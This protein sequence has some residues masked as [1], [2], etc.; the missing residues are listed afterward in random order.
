MSRIYTA[1]ASRWRARLPFLL[2]GLFVLLVVAIVASRLLGLWGAETAA[3]GSNDITVTYATEGDAPGSGVVNSPLKV[4]VTVPWSTGSQDTVLA[5]VALQLLDDAGNPAVFGNGPENEAFAMKPTFDIAVW[6]WRGSVPSKPGKYH[7]RINIDALYNKARNGVV[8]LS[9]PTV[10]AKPVAGAPLT[11]GFVFSQD[12]NLW[13]LSSDAT[14]QRKITFFPE[15]YEY[16]DKPVWSP[17]GSKIAFTYSPRTDPSALPATDIWQVGA[18]G[19][20]AKP[21]VEHGDGESLLD[22]AWSADGKYVYYTVDTSASATYT[23]TLGMPGGGLM[24]TSVRIDRT[25]IATGIREQWMPASQMP[26]SGEANGDTVYLEYIQ[27]RG[28]AE[29][30]V[31]PPQ[32]LMRADA[33]G[34]KTTVLADENAFQLMYAPRMSPDG[35]WVVFGAINIPPPNQP[36]PAPADT[37][38]GGFNLLQWMGFEPTT[39]Q[40]HGMPWDVYM[41][42]ATGGPGIRLTKLDEDQPYPVWLDNS[43]IAFM[44]TTGLYKL[45]IGEDG[46]PKGDPTKIHDGAPHGGLSWRAP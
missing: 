19:S 11:S 20:G 41:V 32:R 8:D 25:E 44:G 38:P 13:L 35:K 15:F 30:L 26:A 9:N 27:P 10:E 42:P 28:N 14:R 22:P 18:D 37:P 29:G 45:S 7:A 16:A 21:I 12:A 23:D 5:S 43:T 4:S 36:L 2:V 17:D 24:G 3:S 39:A 33:S 34:E 31:A 6:E 1:P 40:A 46:Q